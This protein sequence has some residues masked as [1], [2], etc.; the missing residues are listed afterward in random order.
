MGEHHH[1]FDFLPGLYDLEQNLGAQLGVAQSHGAYSLWHVVMAAFVV[2]LVAVLLL[3][4]GFN[5]MPADQR[6]IPEDRLSAR[7]FFELLLEGVR[8]MAM[9][10]I[11]EKHVDR[12]LPLLGTLAVFILFSNLLGLIPGMQPPTS[13]L[14][15]TLACAVPVFLYTHWAG[16]REHGIGYFKHFLGPIIAWYALPLMAIML[17][18]ELISHFARVLSLSMRLFGNMF[19]DHLV[20]GK[21]MAL[22]A[23]PLLYPV[24]IMLLGVM[25]CVV[26]TLVFC[27][28]SMV[29][30]GLAVAHEEH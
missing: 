9:D 21:F 17:L 28:L 12:F 16:V 8:G 7:T 22:L 6:I 24:P 1:W 3:R 20:L 4:A 2:L 5:R 14:N 26:Q 27:L 15:T 25:V 13:T 29:Y 23:I 11:G 19:G 10:I 30:F 18:I